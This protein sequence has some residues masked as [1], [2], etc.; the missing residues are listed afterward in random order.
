MP[1]NRI[2]QT[3]MALEGRQINIPFAP[4][5]PCLPTGSFGHQ[6][7]AKLMTVTASECHR[8]VMTHSRPWLL[9]GVHR[10]LPEV[11]HPLQSLTNLP[12]LTNL[13]TLPGWISFS[14][15][16][17]FGQSPRHIC[18]WKQQSVLYSTTWIN[19]K[20]VILRK[21]ADKKNVYNMIPLIK[22]KNRQSWTLLFRVHSEETK[23]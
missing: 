19:L 23:L 5:H 16:Y 22:F 1:K 6:S 12:F 21:K 13:S 3:Y 2:F 20:T 17:C 9:R 10:I 4:H 8:T 7:D 14:Y 18:N 11:L 15:K